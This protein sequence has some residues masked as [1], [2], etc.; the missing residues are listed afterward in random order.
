MID[1]IGLEY[2]NTQRIGHFLRLALHFH[3]E[4]QDRCISVGVK[5][6]LEREIGLVITAIKSKTNW[7]IHKKKNNNNDNNNNDNHNNTSGN[8]YYQRAQR[9]KFSCS[10][11]LQPLRAGSAS[12][13]ELKSQRCHSLSILGSLF[14]KPHS[15]HRKQ[16]ALTRDVRS[17]AR[18]EGT[19]DIRDSIVLLR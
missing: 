9:N 13:I 17:F 5:I 8:H 18:Q 7:S 14:V 10:N 6:Q 16:L 1:N 3:I 19:F 11:D 15:E 2:F 4:G 12:I